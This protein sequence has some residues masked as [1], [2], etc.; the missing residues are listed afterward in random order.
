M[1]QGI[2]KGMQKGM[3]QGMQNMILDA[4]ETRF[5]KCPEHIRNRITGTTDSEKLKVIMQKLL[6]IE[7]IDEFE[8]DVIWN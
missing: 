4:F 6:T 7:S 8:N 5:G 3:Q 2:Q 1:Q